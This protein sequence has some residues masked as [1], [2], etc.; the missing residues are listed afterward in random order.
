M[1]VFNQ[2]CIISPSFATSLKIKFKSKTAGSR[3]GSRP[4]H[5]GTKGDAA[6]EGVIRYLCIPTP[7]RGNE[8]KREL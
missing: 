2:V 6:I 7:E 8:E 5:V 3:P 1:L 4:E